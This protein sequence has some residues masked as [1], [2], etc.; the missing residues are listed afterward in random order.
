MDLCLLNR[1]SDYESGSR[2]VYFSRQYSTEPGRA[3]GSGNAP[4]PPGLTPARSKQYM[5]NLLDAQRI[6]HHDVAKEATASENTSKTA[7]NKNEPSPGKLTFDETRKVAHMADS[8][9]TVVAP[10]EE[11]IDVNIVEGGSKYSVDAIWKKVKAELQ[12]LRDGTL[13]LGAE[14]KIST[15][16]VIKKS[17]GYELTRRENR[18]V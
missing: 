2:A 18:Q 17:A 10:R 8:H 1:S 5:K 12:H 4:P 11:P 13:L 16:L 6:P 14:V 7:A 15:K 9:N 3:S